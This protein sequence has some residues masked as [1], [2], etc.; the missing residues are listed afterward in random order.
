MAHLLKLKSLFSS[1]FGPAMAV[2][3]VAVLLGYAIFGGNGL[4]A[5][6][7][8]SS[9]LHDSMAE[10]KIVQ[11]ERDR[12]LNR[13]KLLD[14]RHVDPDL[15]DEMIRQELNVGHPDEVVVPLR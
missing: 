8:Y 11:A 4:L 3:L 5:W 12:I 2:L 10:L 15:A 6:G 7:G 14:P 9:K 1:A 13:V